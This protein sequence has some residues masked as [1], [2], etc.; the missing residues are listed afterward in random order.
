M[1]FTS[2]VVTGSTDGDVQSGNQG[3]GDH[4]LVKL[5]GGGEIIWEKTFGGSNEKDGKYSIN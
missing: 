4:W 2:L 3:Y 1:F 5:N